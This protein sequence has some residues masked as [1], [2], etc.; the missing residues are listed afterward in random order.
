MGRKRHIAVDTIGLLLAVVVHPA[1]IQARWCKVGHQQAGRK[2]SVP[3]IDLGGRWLRW[4]VGRLGDV[5]IG[6]GVGDCEA[7]ERQASF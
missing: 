5:P 2:V 1:D 7:S 6:V 3:A 4:S